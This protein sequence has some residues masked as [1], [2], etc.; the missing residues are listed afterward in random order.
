V[1]QKVSAHHGFKGQLLV[2]LLQ[3]DEN[4]GK[5]KSLDLCGRRELAI[6]HNTAPDPR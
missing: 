4:I 6:N 2:F 5:E 3:Q 1:P